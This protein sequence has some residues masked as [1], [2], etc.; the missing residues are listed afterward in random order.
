MLNRIELFN[1]L[2]GRQFGAMTSATFYGGAFQDN[3]ETKEQTIT[4]K[5]SRKANRVDITL[6]NDLYTLTFCSHTPR[7]S[8][9]VKSYDSISG[10]QL[11]HIF[12]A[13]TGLY[14]TL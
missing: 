11:R 4:F 9:N 14:C 3:P 5:G 8:K 7:A 12:T 1:Q 6:E 2:G 10:D 13:H